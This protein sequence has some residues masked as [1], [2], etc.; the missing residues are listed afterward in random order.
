MNIKQRLWQQISRMFFRDEVR[1]VSTELDEVEAELSMLRTMVRSRPH[2]MQMMALQ[3]TDQRYINLIQRLLA[4]EGITTGRA[5]EQDRLIVVEESRALMETDPVAER[6]IH[7]WTQYGFGLGWSIVP[8]DS[9]AKSLWKDYWT[10]RRNNAVFSSRVLQE[11]SDVTLRDGELFYVHF[12]SRLTGKTTTRVIMTEE[13]KKIITDPGDSGTN[14]Y[15]KRIINRAQAQQTNFVV[16]VQQPSGEELYYL[17]YRLRPEDDSVKRTKLPPGAKVA[18]E[19]NPKT[20]VALMP[21]Q[22]RVRGFGPSRGWPLNATSHAWQRGYQEFMQN[23]MAVS[24]AV[25][26]YVDKLIVKGGSRQVDA[27]RARLTAAIS[28][29]G[30]YGLT[31]VPTP[32]SDWIENEALTRTRMSLTTGAGDAR[33]DGGALIGQAGLAG[34][35]PPQLLGRGEVVRME[36]ATSMMPPVYAQFVG[37]QTFWASVWEDL[38]EFVLSMYEYFG[39]RVQFENK[40]A[41]IVSN[42]LHH[43]SLEQVVQAVSLVQSM[44]ATGMLDDEVIEQVSMQLLRMALVTLGIRDVE[45][46]LE[47][48]PEETSRIVPSTLQLVESHEGVLVIHKCPFCPGDQ[49]KRFDDHGG[50]MVCQACGKTID[51]TQE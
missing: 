8:V 47:P 51:P 30:K 44:E 22:H 35:I 50:L 49:V 25:A 48:E 37:Y 41:K 24:R 43:T 40:E 32:A 11:N 17:D 36:V 12:T 2:A 42:D 26:T 4:A 7:L 34:G 6:I 10:S 3:E 29:T 13:I 14:V 33:T 19:V 5:T 46:V 38:V 45:A 9:K 28:N 1:L 27:I 18:H 21:V 15:Y 39:E 31:D 23:R 16:Q 20:Y